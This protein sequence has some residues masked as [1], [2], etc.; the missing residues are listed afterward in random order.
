MECVQN[1]K[2]DIFCLR[3]WSSSECVGEE[4]MLLTEWR[5]VWR[6]TEMECVWS[7]EVDIFCLRHW[8]IEV[9]PDSGRD[10]GGVDGSSGGMCKITL[11]RY[12][13][14]PTN[15]IITLI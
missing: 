9:S 2:V 4:M 8:P 6:V 7:V 14:T 10:E 13:C 15:S 12:Y 5:D 1:V 11:H 3:H